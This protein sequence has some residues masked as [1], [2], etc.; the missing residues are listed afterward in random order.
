MTKKVRQ[1]FRRMVKP[2]RLEGFFKWATV[3]RGYWAAGLKMQSGTVSV[4][5]LWFSVEDML[6]APSRS[7]SEDMF[8]IFSKVAFL[9][10]CYRHYHKNSEPFWCEADSLLATRLDDLVS[11][12][13]EL[14]RHGPDAYEDLWAPFAATPQ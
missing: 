7:M 10:H 6:P 9:R 14:S 4:E 5:R 3:A 1:H 11:H 8:H 2:L 13:R 12:L